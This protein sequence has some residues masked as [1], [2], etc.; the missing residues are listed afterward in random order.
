MSGYS[1]LARPAIFVLAAIGLSGIAPI[2][3]QQLSGESACPA[4]GAAPVCYVV[5]LGYGLIVT[6]ALITARIRP[7]VFF[8]G[9]GPLFLLALIGSSLANETENSAR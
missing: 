6:S 3:Y 1:K 9:W 8:A 4:L 2:A 5:L 7:I